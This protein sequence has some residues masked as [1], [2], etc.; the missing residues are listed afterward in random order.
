MDKP[1]DKESSQCCK[2]DNMNMDELQNSI[3]Q[4]I[5]IVKH[6]IKYSNKQFKNMNKK[7]DQKYYD[8]YSDAL[9]N[10]KK[11]FKTNENINTM[12]WIVFNG[13][14]NASNWDNLTD[15]GY[16]RTIIEKFNKYYKL[17]SIAKIIRKCRC[18][19]N[20]KS[21]FGRGWAIAS[22]RSKDQEAFWL[23]T[24]KGLYKSIDYQYVHR[25]CIFDFYDQFNQII[26]EAKLSFDDIEPKQFKKYRKEFPEAGIVYL[27]GY[28]TVAYVEFKPSDSS[29]KIIKTYTA[30]QYNDF[31]YNR[32]YYEDNICY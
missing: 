22:K 16:D 25:N 2:V 4:M 6:E 29:L 8:L 13:G 14:K 30:N 1:V 9:I 20:P 7:Y 26:Y 18:V 12:R 15:R 5:E 17:Q 3:K 27:I 28:D 19:T 23:K 11:S 10:M 31:Y 21:T 24:L 32:E